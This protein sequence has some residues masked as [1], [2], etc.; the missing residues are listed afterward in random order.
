MKNKV[1]SQM[2][3]FRYP[4]EKKDILVKEYGAQLPDLL[5][6]YCDALILGTSIDRKDPIVRQI[7]RETFFVDKCKSD[8]KS[9]EIIE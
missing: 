4:S 8:P 2:I 1:S 3:G 9:E 5:R 7:M 6:R